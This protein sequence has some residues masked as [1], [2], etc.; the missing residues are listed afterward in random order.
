MW[1]WHRIVEEMPSPYL[2]ANAAS[3]GLVSNFSEDNNC[4]FVFF[5]EENYAEVSNVDKHN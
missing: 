1:Q 5:Y 2:R 3:Q 4:N